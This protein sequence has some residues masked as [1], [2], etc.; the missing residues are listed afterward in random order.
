MTDE[1][2][3]VLI[4]NDDRSLAEVVGYLLEQSFAVRIADDGCEALQMLRDGFRPCCIL[5]DLMMPAMSGFE[6]RA[7]QLRDPGLAEIPVIVFSAV[8]D[9]YRGRK[10]E[11]CAAAYVRIPDD[12]YRLPE[13]I[14]QH[15]LR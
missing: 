7:E 10:E 8:A 11:L 13:L 12:I 14:E 4:V 3:T 1:R 15:R 2:P 6:F 9:L 5:L